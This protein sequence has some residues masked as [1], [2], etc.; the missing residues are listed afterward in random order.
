MNTT[1]DPDRLVRA[2]LDE[3]TTQLPDRAFDEIR[4]AIE[5]T[6]QRVVIGPWREPRMSNLMRLVAAAAVVAV[7]VAGIALLPKFGGVGNAS[8]SPSDSPTAAPTATGAELPTASPNPTPAGGEQATGSCTLTV[9]S[10]QHGGITLS[11]PYV[12]QMEPDTHAV[13]GPAETLPAAP[14]AHLDFEVTDVPAGGAATAPTVEI[15]PSPN[16]PTTGFSTIGAP[17]PTGVVA[18]T[19]IFDSPGDWWV[20][21]EMPDA[22][23]VWQFHV[24]VRASLG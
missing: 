21:L 2:F 10:P 22:G 9:T 23:C 16:S 11:P 18:G 14:Y 5:D 20:R 12:M 3:G 19:A 24:L 8:P 1:R 15:L 6:R 17:G 4:V 13:L 7:V